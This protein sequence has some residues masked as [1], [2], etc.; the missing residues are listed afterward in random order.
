[1]FIFFIDGNV[2]NPI[3]KI[4][5]QDK[6]Q[7]SNSEKKQKNLMDASR[8]SSVSSFVSSKKNSTT[9]LD[10]SFAKIDFSRMRSRKDDD[11]YKAHSGKRYYTVMIESIHYICN[12]CSNIFFVCRN[13]VI[14]G[15][16][17]TMRWQT[18]I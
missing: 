6:L 2:S 15:I 9:P 3:F 5:Q 16:I 17:I 12:V 8:Q 10:D 4:S 13:V 18:N 14:N 7:R 1:M 11:K